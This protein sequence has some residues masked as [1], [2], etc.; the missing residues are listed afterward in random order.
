[1]MQGAPAPSGIQAGLQRTWTQWALE[2]TQP[3]YLF[4]DLL[5]C[6]PIATEQPR[7][8][9]RLLMSGRCGH[10]PRPEGRAVLAS[11]LQHP[12]ALGQPGVG[13]QVSFQAQWVLPCSLGNAVRH[14]SGEKGWL[15]PELFNC[16]TVSFMDLKAMVGCALGTHGRALGV[17]APGIA[18]AQAGPWRPSPPPFPDLSPRLGLQTRG[19]RVWAPRPQLP[20]PCP[21]PHPPGLF[22]QVLLSLTHPPFVCH[23]HLGVWGFLKFFPEKG[24]STGKRRALCP[25]K[26]QGPTWR[27]LP[28]PEREAEPE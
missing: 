3:I 18:W 7:S 4:T 25:G 12:W 11:W 24:V 23:G 26:G 14:C 27:L 1:M 20:T 16:T 2:T 28:D 9:V 5:S 8:V 19:P 21:V 6:P 15:P 10:G 22:L 13:S 17:Q